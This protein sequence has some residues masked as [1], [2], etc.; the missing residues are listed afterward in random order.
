M[1]TVLIKLLSGIVIG[2][3]KKI[4]LGLK[5]GKKKLIRKKFLKLFS[6]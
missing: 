2:G 6:K 3:L 4:V 1:R 5:E